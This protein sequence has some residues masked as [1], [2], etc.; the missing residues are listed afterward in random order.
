MNNGSAPC[1]LSACLGRLEAVRVFLR[2]EDNL[3][4][5]ANEGDTEA[6]EAAAHMNHEDMVTLQCDFGVDT[7]GTALCAAIEGRAEACVKLLMRRRGGYIILCRYLAY[8]NI[9][10]RL[11]QPS[12]AQL[13]PGALSCSQ[14]RE[15]FAR[16]RSRHNIESPIKLDDSTKAIDTPLVAATTLRHAEK[17]AKVGDDNLDGVKGV[18]RSLHQAEAA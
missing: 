10:P 6:R 8:I 5:G 14:I 1:Y 12:P 11:G 13:R 7:A 15:A 18:V 2:A 4:L 3:Q 16:P 17:D 9:T